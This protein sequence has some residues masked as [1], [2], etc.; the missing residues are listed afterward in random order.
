MSKICKRVSSTKAKRQKSLNGTKIINEI[1]DF[2]LQ[3]VHNKNHSSCHV[4]AVGTI[5][6][7]S[8]LKKGPIFENIHGLSKIT[9]SNIEEWDVVFVLNPATK[10]VVSIVPLFP[11]LKGQSSFSFAVNGTVGTK[12]HQAVGCQWVLDK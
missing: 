11:R 12:L 7:A 3:S 2:A 8:S 9:L 5:L 4:V 1:H 6:F 10:R